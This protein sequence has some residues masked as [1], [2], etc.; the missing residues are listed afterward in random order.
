MR[1]GGAKDGLV[2]SDDDAD[3]GDDGLVRF[4]PTDIWGSTQRANQA[5][6]IQKM[7]APTA[8]TAPLWRSRGRQAQGEG[9]KFCQISD[10]ARSPTEVPLVVT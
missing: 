8:G 6:P 1:K 3:D 4:G 2:R 10:I 9:S 5:K 7:K